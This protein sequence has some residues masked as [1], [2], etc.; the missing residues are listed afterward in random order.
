LKKLSD[1]TN[2]NRNIWI[3][4][5]TVDKNKN[6]KLGGYTLS[7]TVVKKLSDSYN[8]SILQNIVYEPLRD[9]RIFKFSIDA[10]NLTGGKKNEEKK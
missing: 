2:Q 5:L 9:T 4:Q 1:F 6:L 7:R 8:S 3:N 10:G